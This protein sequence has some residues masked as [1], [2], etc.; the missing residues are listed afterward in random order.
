MIVFQNLRPKC[1][2]IDSKCNIKIGSFGLAKNENSES[3]SYF[4]KAVRK[5]YQA[6]EI[7]L[8]IA[9]SFKGIF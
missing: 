7:L 5:E 9:Y 4:P 8:E 1:I 2:F 3:P 6:P